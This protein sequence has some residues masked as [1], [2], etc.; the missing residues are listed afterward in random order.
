[1]RGKGSV[2]EDGIATCRDDSASTL[3]LLSIT[4]EPEQGERGEA[5]GSDQGAAVTRQKNQA[6][7][8][9]PDGDIGGDFLLIATNKVWA[10]GIIVE[11]WDRVDRYDW[12]C[13]HGLLVSDARNHRM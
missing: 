2:G 1:M 6:S 4:Q 9:R 3:R 5:C 7:S 10:V 12:H 11:V 13:S 8:F